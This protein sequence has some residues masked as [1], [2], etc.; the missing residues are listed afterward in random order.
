[1]NKVLIVGMGEVGLAHANILSKSYEV[2]GID[3]DIEKVPQEFRI[4]KDEIFNC[5]VMLV[6]I[7][8]SEDFVKTVSELIKIH[9]PSHFVNV[10]STVP[11]GTCE[12]IG[13]SVSHSTTRGLH[14]N[15]E[16]GLLNIIKHIGGHNHQD[17]SNFYK[18]AGISTISTGQARTTEMA[19]ILNNCSYG[20]NL[21]WAD[22]MQKLCRTFGV[23][24]FEAVM[25]YTLSN[26]VGFQKISQASKSRMIL[27]P[28]N[29]KIGGHCVV[30]AANLIEEN[31]RTPMLKILS[32][33]NERN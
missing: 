17:V 27:T 15:L 6:A 31:L 1:M 22:E 28:P 13:P 12:K 24:Y 3:L 10:L 7:P 18:K 8:Y 30:Q 32:K 11:P 29:G 14:P 21:I 9:K 33:Y 19:H 26:N 23:D 16:N 25:L 2:K 4:G 5:S 20:I